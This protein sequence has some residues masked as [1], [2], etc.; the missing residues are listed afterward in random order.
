MGFARCAGGT[1]MMGGAEEGESNPYRSMY[2]TH[3]IRERYFD[4]GLLVCL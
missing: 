2:G 4:L 1:M 3:S